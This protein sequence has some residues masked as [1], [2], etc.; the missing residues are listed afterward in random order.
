MLTGGPRGPWWGRVTSVFA[1]RVLASEDVIL[2]SRF[3]VVCPY[4]GRSTSKSGRWSPDL[5]CR[6]VVQ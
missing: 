6:R 5:T 3:L 2:H 4:G 1:M